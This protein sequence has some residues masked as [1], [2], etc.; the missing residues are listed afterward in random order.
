MRK[1][2]FVLL[3][4]GALLTGCFQI[5]TDYVVNEDGS[6]SQ[7]VRFAIP[8]EVLAQ[9]G[10][11]MPS[12]EEAQNDPQMQALRDALGDRGSLEFF[13]SEEEGFGFE[14]TVNVPPSDDFSAALQSILDELP[15]DGELPTEQIT[16]ELPVLR[17]SGDEW[18]FSFELDISQEELSAAA[19]DE[20]SAAFASLFMDQSSVITRLRLPG[21]VV[22]HN[23]D[24]VL[25]DGTLVWT[26]EGLGEPR[27][28]TAR[29]DISGG[30]GSGVRIVL[31]IAGALA[32]AGTIAVLAYFAMRRSSGGEAPPA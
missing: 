31:I 29:S 24:E 1:L 16:S 26:Q 8:G 5:E 7:T 11:E 20:E 9:M 23:A 17:R 32:V 13:A 18:D 30:G 3:P 22:E 2:L 28:L 6:G 19:G 4:L 12:L 10:G 25:E 15:Q 14:M 27:T 21:E